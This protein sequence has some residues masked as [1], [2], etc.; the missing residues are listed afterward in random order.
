MPVMPLE[1]RWRRSATGP[2]FVQACASHRQHQSHFAV[3]HPRTAAPC[4]TLQS[5]CSS[6][7]LAVEERPQTAR[8]FACS[9]A[10]L[11]GCD[12]FDGQGRVGTGLR[13]L[14]I[15]VVVEQPL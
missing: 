2:S 15:A 1:L 5:N 4:P 6:W 11:W 8:H 13:G 7:T 12:A 9:A 14:E 3:L 10:H